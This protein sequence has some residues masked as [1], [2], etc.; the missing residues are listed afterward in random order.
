VKVDPKFV[1]TFDGFFDPNFADL[2][3]H[4][5]VGVMERYVLH[6]LHPGGFFS[7]LLA[8]NMMDAMAR[9]HLLN[10]TKDIKMLCLWVVNICP[11]E[12]WG[13]YEKVV[14]WCKLDE[15]ARRIILE[16]RNLVTTVVDI[17]KE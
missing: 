10:P 11:Y 14:A 9:C 3:D 16:E 8:N 15:K 7:S 6:G 13:S 12:A 1:A 4:E 5:W 17:L 2:S